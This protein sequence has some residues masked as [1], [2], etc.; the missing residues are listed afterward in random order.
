MDVQE[1]ARHQ[2]PAQEHDAGTALPAV[3]SLLDD[4]LSAAALRAFALYCQGLQTS[5]IAAILGVSPRTV[6]RYLAATRRINAEDTRLDRRENLQRAIEAQLAVAS[7]AWSEVERERQYELELRDGKHDRTKRRVIRRPR[8]HGRGEPAGTGLE[9][10]E[11]LE[12][13]TERPHHVSQT[14]RLL[15]VAHAA[16]ARIAQ[17]QGLFEPLPADPA[18]VHVTLTRQLDAPTSGPVGIEPAPSAEEEERH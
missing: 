15:A 3:A 8:P 9:E 5:Q 11:V 17:L 1:D 7:A 16:H 6:R 2:T 18:A 4:V 14:A 13:E 12:E 10:W